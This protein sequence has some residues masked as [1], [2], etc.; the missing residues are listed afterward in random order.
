MSRIHVIFIGLLISALRIQVL[1]QD[2]PAQPSQKSFALPADNYYI[3]SNE[4]LAKSKPDVTKVYGKIKF[5]TSFPDYKVKVVENF[6]DLNVKIVEHFADEAGE[7]QIVE[8]FPNFK[9]QIV[10]NF[11]DFTIKYVEDFPG[12]P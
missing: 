3:V 11:P 10:E 1:A 9:I 2:L 12:K 4:V 6:A 8:N 7:W 5:V